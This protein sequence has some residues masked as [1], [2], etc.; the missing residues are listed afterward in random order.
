MKR[1]PLS[2]KYGEVRE[3]TTADFKTARPATEVLP[4]ELVGVLPKRGRPPKAN[5]KKQLTLRLDTNIV[6]YF[7]SHGKGWQ[8]ELNEVLQNYVSEHQ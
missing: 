6:E 8:T 7:K 2:D 5:P 4:A 3:L 1:Q